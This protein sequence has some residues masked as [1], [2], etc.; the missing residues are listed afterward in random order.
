MKEIEENFKQI[1]ETLK[2]GFDSIIALSELSVNE[3]LNNE[4]KII[5]KWQ[6]K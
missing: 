6:K 4:I 1:E 2:K 3:D 5:A